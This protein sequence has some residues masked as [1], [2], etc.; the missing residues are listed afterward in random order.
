MF[1]G[2]KLTSGGLSEPLGDVLPGS[3]YA[4]VFP[5]STPCKCVSRIRSIAISREAYWR[6]FIIRLV[7][8][9]ILIVITTKPLLR[10]KTFSRNV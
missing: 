1:P 6:G 4:N 7:F 9:K 2:T 3:L 8:N 10:P 5:E